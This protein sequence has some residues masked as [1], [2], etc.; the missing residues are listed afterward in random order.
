MEEKPMKRYTWLGLLA[1]FALV[2][3]ACGGTGG[4]ATTTTSGTGTT[5]APGTT[6]PGT[7]AGSGGELTLIMWQAPDTLNN[8]L[9]SGTKDT[10]GASLIL[11]PLANFGPET[12]I[13]PRLAAE[14][15]TLENGGH[16][17]DLMSVT[18]TLKEGVVWS[19]GTP[20]TAEDV[21]FTYEYCMAEGSGCAQSG[22]FLGVAN[23][24]A[25]G[26]LSVTITFD[27]PTAYP[28]LP[29]VGAVSPI[30][31]KAQFEDCLGAA[32]AGCTEENFAPIGTGPFVVTNFA[33]GDTVEYAINPLYR[34][35]DEG[36]PFFGTVKV[37]G[38]GD[39]EA[40]ARRTLVTGEADYSW[41][42]QVP[43]DILNPMVAEGRGSLEVA[44]AGNIEHLN[45]NQTDPRNPA[46]PSDYLDGNNPHPVFYRNFEFSKALS[47]ALDRDI[48]TERGY[49]VAGAPTCNIW[50]SPPAVST[51]H[52]FCLTQ[53]IAE[54]NRILDELG[55][56]DTNNDGIRE[57]PVFG[58]LVFTFNTS[59]N[60]VRQEFQDLI[61][62]WWLEI[63][64]GA[65]MRNTPA[66]VFFGGGVDADNI[67]RF[68][69][70]IQ[71]YTFVPLPGGQSHFAG[72]TTAEI[73][74]S[75]NGWGGANLVRYSNS[76]YDALYAELSRTTDQDARNELIKQL[77]D[78]VVG[79]GAVIS[80]VWRASASAFSNE[81][82]G[83]NPLNGWDSEYWNIADWYKE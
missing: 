82:K 73:P 47:L 13:I 69:G 10:M 60:A 65:Q 37:L 11:E 50:P 32:A 20:L 21:V 76:D 6:A 29:F 74:Q 54:A 24:V 17:A 52:D 83:W 8:Y 51:T 68:D 27:S 1:A 59:T 40:A 41:N 19:D 44:F 22:A 61:Q 78:L 33:V 58:E 5:A 66:T 30:I 36:K 45:L 14:I 25:D 75:S 34:G 64:I 35:V 63:G 46:G 18:W 28:Y 15:P 81:L 43:P 56:M 48:L 7:Q 77:S 72:Y 67:T 3:A 26:E 71:M 39:A 38:G 4:E 31:Q 80:L 53:D 12:E 62:A 9:S 23:V 57:H 42:L 55:Y 79:D 70:D 16:A 2:L 49:G